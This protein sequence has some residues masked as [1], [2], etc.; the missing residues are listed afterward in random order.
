M[1]ALKGSAFGIGTDIG[2]SVSMPASFQGVFSIKPSVG[3]L[4][5]KDVANTGPGQQIMPTV[6]GVMGH[7]IATLRLVFKSLVSTRPWLYDPYSLPIPWRS[8]N[9]YNPEQEAHKPAFGFMPN[10]GLVT[11]HPPVA[12]ALRIVQRALEESDYQLLD[13]QPPSNTESIEIHVRFH[14][15]A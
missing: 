4:S 15:L 11:P 1:Q 10:D 7:S 2:G 3:R 14:K 9:E 5:F 6:A 13:W 8:E 12:R